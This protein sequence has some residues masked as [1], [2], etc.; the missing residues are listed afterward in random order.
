MTGSKY[1]WYNGILLLA[2]FFGCRLVWGTYQ[3]IRV[4]Q[5]VWAALHLPVDSSGHLLEE[6]FQGNVT[7]SI[8]DN[9][10]VP[11]GGGLCLG[12]AECVAAQNEIVRFVGPKTDAVPVWLAVTYLSS[13]IVLNSL[14]FYWF[15]KMIETVRKRFDGAKGAAPPQKGVQLANVVPLSSSS[16]SS[17]AHASGTDTKNKVVNN[18]EVK[19]GKSGRGRR[20]RTDSIILDVADGLERD[21]RLGMMPDTPGSPAPTPTTTTTATTTTTTSP[22]QLE[23]RQ[24]SS[25]SQPNTNGPIAVK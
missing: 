22:S 15:G 23:D 21:E 1:Q 7:N 12:R 14:N 10:L 8:A 6:I 19:G 11:P 17:V 2:T 18:N 13:N 16:S 24:P 25:F 20:R 5:D 9:L 3:S 4:Y